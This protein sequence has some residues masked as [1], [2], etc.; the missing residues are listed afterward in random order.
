LAL[1]CARSEIPVGCVLTPDRFEPVHSATEPP[2]AL[3]SAARNGRMNES[4]QPGS[5]IEASRPLGSHGGSLVVFFLVTYAVTWFFFITGGTL[6]AHAM[7]SA[8]ALLLELLLL[9]GTIAPSVVA[10]WLTARAEGRAGVQALLRRIFQW[11][12][13]LR[14]YVFAVGYMGAIKLAAALAHQVATGE[15][16]LFGD[17]PWYVMAAVIPVS[18]WVQ[19]GEE[20][21]WRGYALPRLA[22]R[23]GLAP[24]SVVLGLIWATWHLP[25]FFIPGASTAGQSFPLYVLQVTAL[26]VA[27]A[28]LYWRTSGS[29]LLVMLMHAAVNNT[30]DIVPSGV[31]GATNV[32]GGSPSLVAWLTLAF[33]WMAAAYFLLRMSMARRRGTR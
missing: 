11:R 12:V 33:L 19:A 8:P 4:T 30:K 22:A 14:W 17:T 26:S 6:S 25:L 2:Y 24:A 3:R 13:A 18:M 21:G 16:P 15:W 29:L 7:P 9:P 27:I 20:I 32:F 28:F 31:S 1:K 5:P 10:L 23:L